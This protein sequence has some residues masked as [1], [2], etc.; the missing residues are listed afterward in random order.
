MAEKRAWKVWVEEKKGQNREFQGDK[1]KNE[2]LEKM[3][4][5]FETKG[6][7]IGKMVGEADPA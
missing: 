1:T 4:E 3:G 2:K 6:Q 5:E 7:E